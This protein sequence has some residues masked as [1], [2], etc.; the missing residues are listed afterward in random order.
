MK[1]VLS[2]RLKNKAKT[3]NIRITKK[4]NRK[5]VYKTNNELIKQIKQK[6]QKKIKILKTKKSS[7]GGLTDM[8]PELLDNIWDINQHEPHCIRASEFLLQWTKQE[9]IMQFTIMLDPA[10]ARPAIVR[11]KTAITSKLA[12]LWP[13]ALPL[14][15]DNANG[16]AKNWNV[17]TANA[18]MVTTAEFIA[19]ADAVTQEFLAE[20]NYVSLDRQETHHTGI[21]TSFVRYRICRQ[22]EVKPT[23]I[24]LTS[25]QRKYL[26]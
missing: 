12:A 26:R 7:F 11:F 17:R 23:N 5:R 24:L 25:A 6:L 3:L 8:P 1:S 10:V 15:A 2:K 14:R 22:M 18:T 13:Q 9:D 21:L 19:L 4:V 20:N 16:P